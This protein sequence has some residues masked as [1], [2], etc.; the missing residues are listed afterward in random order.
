MAVI[1]FVT[2][3]M[4]SVMTATRT[5]SSIPFNATLVNG[6]SLGQFA[7]VREAQRVIEQTVGGRFLRWIDVQRIDSIEQYRGEE[8]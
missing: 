2:R 6:V 4:G 3:A 5:G 8:A 1:G 7:S